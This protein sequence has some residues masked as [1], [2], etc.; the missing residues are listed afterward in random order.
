MGKVNWDGKILE[1]SDVQCDWVKV[2]EIPPEN[3]CIAVLWSSQVHPRWGNEN[4]GVWLSDQVTDDLQADLAVL[5]LFLSVT[6]ICSFSS[7]RGYLPGSAEMRGNLMDTSVEQELIRELSQKK[8]NL[9]L[10]LHN[11][12]ENA[13]VGH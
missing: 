1:K 5:G 10:E 2:P 3:V 13:K 9:L 8:Q 7:V 6:R 12:E 11:Y 4:L